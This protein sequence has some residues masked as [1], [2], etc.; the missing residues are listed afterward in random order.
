MPVFAVWKVKISKKGFFCCTSVKQA[1]K[2][3]LDFT[4]AGETPWTSLISAMSRSIL[5]THAVTMEYS[6]VDTHLPNTKT[7][8]R[9]KKFSVHVGCLKK[10]PCSSHNS[11]SEAAS[12]SGEHKTCTTLHVKRMLWWRLG[13]GGGGLQKSFP[14]WRTSQ[15]RKIDVL[16]G[17]IINNAVRSECRGEQWHCVEKRWRILPS[18]FS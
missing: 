15:K 6:T 1:K 14:R 4:G 17:G 10:L 9:R 5:C 8:E 13:G 11:T 3:K 18:F 7:I 12:L 2:K 16:Q